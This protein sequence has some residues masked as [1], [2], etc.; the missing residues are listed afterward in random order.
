VIRMRAVT[1]HGF[2][3]VR[4]EDKPRPEV[5]E[6][7]DALLRVSTTAICGSDL[8]L[9]HDK[10]PGI[11]PG[12]TIGHEFVGEVVAVGEAVR[13]T[14]VG[15][16]Y[17]SS[18][19]PAC[20]TC[21]ACM[22]HDWRNCAHFGVFGFGDA[23]GSLEGGQADYVRVPLADMTLTAVPDELTDEDVI[24][25]GDILATA[26]TGFIRAGVTPGA[27]V[28]IVGAGPV[29]QLA[30]MCAQL[31][32]A[33]KVFSI[34]L[35]PARL[36]EAEAL[37]AIAV[38]ASEVDPSDVVFEQT[39]FLGADAVIE[40]V[41]N[42]RS[43]ETAWSLARTGASIAII[44]VLVDEAFPVSCGDNWL[45]SVQIRPVLGDCLTHRFELVDLIRARK[46][47]PARIISHTLDLADAVDAYRMFD[48]HEATKIVL[49]P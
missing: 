16:R 21:R 20:G 12:T 15:Q 13:E 24:F 23:F 37:G 29:G 44:G 17:V 47:D 27:N 36:K 26:Y 5:V 2:K 11:S 18:M 45:R 28:A 14:A 31:F 1:Y 40:A 46:L 42:E 35:V 48:E 9:Y 39:G 30:V 43:L 19:Y 25:T 8:H 32:G 4:V 22:R 38:N 6:P 49:K 41:G 3:D 33:A 10:M 7:G 34:D